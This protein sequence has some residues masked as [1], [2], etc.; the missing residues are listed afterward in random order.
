[1]F[2]LTEWLSN[3]NYLVNNHDSLIYMGLMYLLAIVIYV[4]ARIVRNR[5]GI[6]LSLI[7]KE[8]PVE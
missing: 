3:N 4:V 6:D 7:N 2:N 8:I 1:V 5:Q